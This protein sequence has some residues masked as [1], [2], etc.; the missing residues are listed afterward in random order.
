MLECYGNKGRVRPA[1]AMT[2]W[3]FVLLI[4]GVLTL[5]A[6]A[7][8]STQSD[9]AA[10]EKRFIAYQSDFIDLA[11]PVQNSDEFEYA[12][13]LATIA[14]ET[15]DQVDAAFVLLQIYD[16]VSCKEDKAKISPLI[17]GQ[18]AT[19]SKYITLS[20]KS[21]NLSLGATKRPG[22]VAEAT[23]MRDDLREI[24]SIFDSIQLP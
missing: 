7:R 2:L 22:L 21:A 3:A 11:K 12:Y 8:S 9:L 10:K 13:S 24:K 15:A 17:R 20:I 4:S 14:G 1:M 5:S 6:Q 16:A 23:Q 18:L 19:Y